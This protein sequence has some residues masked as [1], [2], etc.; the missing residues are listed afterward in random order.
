MIR[1]S[2]R[3]FVHGVVMTCAETAAPRARAARHHLAEHA[4]AHPPDLT[5]AVALGARDRLRA[6]PG[7][8]AA[9]LVAALRD[10]HVDR[11]L[12]AEHRLLERDRDRDLH[13]LAAGRTAGAAPPAAERAAAAEERLEDVAQPTA[14]EQVVHVRHPGLAADA[15]LAE[16]VVAGALLVVGEH[17]VGPRDLL[18]ALGRVRVVGVGV[19]MQ[20]AGPLAVRLL[21]VVG[22]RRPAHAQQFVVV[23]HGHTPNA[24]GRASQRA[25][26]QQRPAW[27]GNAVNIHQP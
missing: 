16:T 18:E 26:G 2:P 11:D 8:G 19:G 1:P 23:S 24:S 10:A 27:P 13:V 22:R 14:A 3:H 17:G 12:V 15:R 9:A 25:S 21:E 4:L 5:R 20:L 7:A 6:L